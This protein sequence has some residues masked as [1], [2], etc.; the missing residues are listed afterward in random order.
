[1]TIYSAPIVGA[2]FRPPAK[3]ILQVLPADCPLVLRHDPENEFSTE[4]IAVYLRS[5][6]IPES[7]R[8]ELEIH[9]PGY[10]FSL[11]SILAQAEWHLGYIAEIGNKKQGP[12]AEEFRNCL[13]LPGPGAEWPARLGFNATGNP[14]AKVDGDL[15][16]A[17]DEEE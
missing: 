7:A 10:G 13:G 12:E 9:G 4:A 3:A 5:A 16:Q 17:S 15:L 8:P 14:M 11:E 6:D 2:H 1:M